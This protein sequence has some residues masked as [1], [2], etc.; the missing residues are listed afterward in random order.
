MHPYQ[1]YTKHNDIGSRVLDK[2]GKAGMRR[3]LV[4]SV[5]RIRKAPKNDIPSILD[6]LRRQA[7]DLGQVQLNYNGGLDAR[8]HLHDATMLLCY[9]SMGVLYSNW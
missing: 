7:A 6:V 4:D 2:Q 3:G 5:E 8:V 1:L 9:F